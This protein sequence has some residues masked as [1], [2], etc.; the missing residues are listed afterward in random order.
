MDAAGASARVVSGLQFARTLDVVMT[1]DRLRALLAEVVK[2]EDHVSAFVTAHGSSLAAV[3]ARERVSAENLMEYVGLRQL[4]LRRLQLEL[5]E[6]G[7]TSLGRCEGR[8]RSSLREL[9]RRLEDSLGI[10]STEAQPALSRA[11]AERL[12]HERT[13]ALFGEWPTDR[14]VSIMVTADDD[15]PTEEACSVLIG[16]GM[17]VL[18]INTAHGSPDTWRATASIVRRVAA[19]MNRKISIEVDLQGSKIRTARMQSAGPAVVRYRPEKDALGRVVRELRVPIVGASDSLPPPGMVPLRVPDAWIGGLRVGDV[20]ETVDS[21]ERRRRFHICEV[22]PRVAV[23]ELDET[24]YLTPACQL[25]WSRDGEPCGTAPV[26][27]IAALESD[28]PLQVGDEVQLWLDG[29]P[30]EAGVRSPVDGRSWL[31]PPRIGLNLDQAA[32]AVAAEHR[33]LLD[34]GKV[35]TVIQAVDNALLHA[36]VVRTVKPVVRVR[37]EKGVNFP[38]SE[39]RAPALSARDREILPAVLEL[40]DIVG[41]SFVRSRSDLHEEIDEIERA[42]GERKPPGIVVKIETA[43]AVAMLP[44]LLL[45]ALQH[46]PVGI[47]IARGDLAAEIGFERLAEVQQEI[48]WF[49]EAAH[50]PVVWAT[51]VLENLAR[52]GIPSRAEVTDASMA[53]Q[54]E[55]VMLNKGPFVADACHTLDAILHR[56]EAHQFKKLSLYRPLE[57]SSLA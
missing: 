56:M 36:R 46:T 14:H 12:L 21:R 10:P 5:G 35:E 53:V 29:R 6:W 17:N 44:T 49:A 7:L 1:K 16:A 25:A 42:S 19:R 54:A 34:D 8:V 13:C 33:V 30:S 9:R 4:D 22:G 15:P 37:A 23:G 55:C 2:I 26:V 28:V 52:T 43:Q 3:P 18:R 31:V 24:C 45:E 20:L 11:D 47:M 50:L 27:G 39:I 40:A 57:I 51:Q 38:D 32:V 48:L 41:V